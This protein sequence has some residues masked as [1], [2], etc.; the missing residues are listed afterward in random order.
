M[1][2]L[3]ANSCAQTRNKEASCSITRRRYSKVPAGPL[4]RA[5]YTL[6]L[7]H[8]EGRSK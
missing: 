2:T 3:Q 4:E 6:I 1:A 8:L 7:S 5:Q